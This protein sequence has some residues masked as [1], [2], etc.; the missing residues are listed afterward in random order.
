MN[1][2]AVLMLEIDS[3]PV[4]VVR[5]QPGRGRDRADAVEQPGALVVGI[6]KYPVPQSRGKKAKVDSVFGESCGRVPMVI[7]EAVDQNV[8]VASQLARSPQGAGAN[9]VLVGRKD[10][11]DRLTNKRYLHGLPS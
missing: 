11:I 5:K 6:E 9:R 7:L 1:H 2:V 4:S 8:R 3:D 10:G